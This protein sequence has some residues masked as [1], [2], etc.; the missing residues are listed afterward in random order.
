[1][2]N[3]KILEAAKRFREDSAKNPRG[4][5]DR[6]R[7]GIED[8]GK[9]L[10]AKLSD[11]S[12]MLLAQRAFA[13]TAK[14]GEPLPRALGRAAISNHANQ[15]MEDMELYALTLELMEGLNHKDSTWRE[16]AQQALTEMLAPKFIEE[17]P[18]E[19]H[20]AGTDLVANTVGKQSG[21]LLKAISDEH[22]PELM[23]GLI[24]LAGKVWRHSVDEGSA[25]GLADAIRNLGKR[26][27]HPATRSSAN[28]L[29]NMIYEHYGPGAKR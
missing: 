14:T 19:A 4:A 20:M 8:L 28:A 1:M 23:G 6:A 17:K 5:L 16:A 13:E 10:R 25:R 2:F 24:E 12:A 18:T 9:S 3:P 7:A 11:D 15:R 27:D 29:A 21:S 26:A 22:R